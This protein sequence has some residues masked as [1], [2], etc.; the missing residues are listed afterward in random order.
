MNRED[1]LHAA[2]VE[3]GIP[4]PLAE[5]SEPEVVWLGEVPPSVENMKRVMRKVEAIQG[6][7]GGVMNDRGP[8][9]RVWPGEFSRKA[10]ELL[11]EIA[12]TP[13]RRGR[14]DIHD[15]GFLPVV[16]RWMF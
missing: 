9:V 5:P 14:R 10:R 6:H 3:D 7:R 16:L 1:F 13:W 4:K 11:D 12:R 8:G 15:L 2:G